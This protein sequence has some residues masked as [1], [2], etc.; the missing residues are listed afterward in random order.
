MSRTGKIRIY[1]LLLIGYI[2]D[3]LVWNQ[4]HYHSESHRTASLITHLFVPGETDPHFT[5]RVKK[6]TA[7]SNEAE[8]KLRRGK[9]SQVWKPDIQHENKGSKQYT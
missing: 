9:M 8:R 5:H 1:P 6:S 4:V 2:A 7:V 3:I